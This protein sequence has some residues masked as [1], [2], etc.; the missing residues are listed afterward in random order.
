MI[1]WCSSIRE[2]LQC[3]PQK[4]EKAR[5]IGEA[6]YLGSAKKQEAL[7]STAGQG[8]PTSPLQHDEKA[9]TDTMTWP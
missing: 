1:D 4:K 5:A 8:L 7:G 2:E 3:I 6:I 9:S